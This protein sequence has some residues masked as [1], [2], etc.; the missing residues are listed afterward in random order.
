MKKLVRGCPLIKP[1][2]TIEKT[3]NF[4]EILLNIWTNLT[5]NF[6]AIACFVLGLP[7]RL[8]NPKNLWGCPF[9]KCESTIE[10]APNFK[11]I[12]LNI[13]TSLSQ[14]F[15][16]VA[17]FVLGLFRRL[18]NPKSLWGC[19]FIKCE[20]TTEK[21]PN[22]QEILLNIPTSLSQNFT[23]IARFILELFR[24]LHSPKNLWRCPFIKR[25]Q[26][27]EKKPNF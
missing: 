8:Q 21:A 6:N 7:R 2:P 22:F 14:N 18:Q 25:E 19:P 11:E 27:I 1:E 16:A 17:S 24:R 20:Q 3:P 23:A 12:L 5:Q 4:Q 26:A 15:N 13:R 9:I 10:K